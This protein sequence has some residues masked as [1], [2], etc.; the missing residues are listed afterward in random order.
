M[1]GHVELSESFWFC[2][3]FIIVS[4]PEY[5]NP[6]SFS[7]IF[8]EGG[9]WG[10]GGSSIWDLCPPPPDWAGAANDLPEII[11]RADLAKP[12]LDLDTRQDKQRGRTWEGRVKEKDPG[13]S[14]RSRQ[15]PPPFSKHLAELEN[16]TGPTFLLAA[17]EAVSSCL[18]PLALEGLG[19]PQEP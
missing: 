18:S 13:L 9:W 8:K 11:Q 1:D 14:L 5:P 7:L 15:A 16:R 6:L 2:L 19:Q 12:I 4:Y 17:I 10:G 3:L